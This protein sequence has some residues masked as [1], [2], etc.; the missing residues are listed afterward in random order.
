MAAAFAASLDLPDPRAGRR[1]GPVRCHTAVDAEQAADSR[2]PCEL[3][4]IGP[5]SAVFSF[6]F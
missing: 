4:T 6:A 3:G 1:A 2:A 5:I